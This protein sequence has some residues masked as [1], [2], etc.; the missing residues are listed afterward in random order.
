MGALKDNRDE[1]Q[2]RNS[3]EGRARSRGGACE[4][5]GCELESNSGIESGASEVG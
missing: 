1:F 3:G 2:C 5:L 4:S